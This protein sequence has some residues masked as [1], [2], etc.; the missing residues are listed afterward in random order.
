[1]ERNNHDYRDP[2]SVE[3]TG[4]TLQGD[5]EIP[6]SLNA[7]RL[8]GQ[9]DAA[10]TLE[11]RVRVLK[12]DELAKVVDEKLEKKY[13]LRDKDRFRQG[14]ESRLRMTLVLDADESNLVFGVIR[15]VATKE[16]KADR[17]S[18]RLAKKM[19]LLFDLRSDL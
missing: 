18:R 15:R 6:L 17:R 16:V 10:A 5:K 9:D 12:P 8:T 4:Y 11:G 14:L 19:T 3:F 7:L 13:Q 1:M 2:K